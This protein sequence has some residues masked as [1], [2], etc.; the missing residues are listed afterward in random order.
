MELI[1]EIF[2]K[3]KFCQKT[4][5]IG[6]DIPF[7]HWRLYFKSSMIS[8]CKKKFNHFGEN[9]DFRAGAYA[10]TCSNISIG[11]NVVIRPNTMIFA[12]KFEEIIIED[13]VMMGAG[14]HFYVNNHKFDRSDIPIIN[15]GYYPSKKVVVKKGAWIGANSIVLSGVTIGQNSVIGAGSIVTKTIP[16]GVVAVG[17][18]ARIIKYLST[19]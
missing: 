18:P 5:R 6:P 10:V 4:D 14:V 2:K 1:I 19:E 17:N 7:T 12:D 3:I 13:N 11:D 8:L 15:Q 16:D 9:S